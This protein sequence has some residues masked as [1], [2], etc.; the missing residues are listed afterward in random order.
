MSTSFTTGKNNNSNSKKNKLT[1]PLVACLLLLLLT[2][3]TVIFPTEGMADMFGFFK[4]YDVHLCPEVKGQILNQGK[5]LAGEKVIRYL[6]YVD[7]KE[8]FDHAI[9]DETGRFSLPEVNIRSK[10]PGNFM[11]E[12]NT[13]QII[14]IEFN[15][16]KHTIWNSSLEGYKPNAAYSRKLSSLNCDL[17]SPTVSFEFTNDKNPQRPHYAVTNCQWDTDFS[18]YHVHTDKD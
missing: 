7:R 9:T 17:S 6:N 14:Y 5:P 1:F 4:K 10:M 3:F 15:N 18:V 2:L 13:L 8:R 12:H 16:E 11:V